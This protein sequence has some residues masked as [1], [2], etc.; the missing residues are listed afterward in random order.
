MPAPVTI[1][2]FGANGQLGFELHRALAPLGPVHALTRKQADLADAHQALRVL[3]VLKPGVVVN[4]AAYT[5]VDKAEREAALCHAINAHTQQRLSQWA[6]GNNARIV[7]YSTDYVF[8]GVKPAAD[9]YREDDAPNPQSVYGQ[10]KL[11]G[12]RLT[13]ASGAAHLI[14]RTSWVV[15]VH[16]GNFAKTMLR[17]ARERDALKVVADQWGAPTTAALIADVTAHVLRAR[18]DGR[19]ADGVYHLAA[20]GVT[21]WCEYARFVIANALEAG[22]KLRITPDDVEAITASQYPTPAKRPANSRLCT[23]KLR[24]TFDLHLPDWRIGVAQ[25]VQQLSE[26]VQ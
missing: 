13:Q 23:D 1:A 5:A 3:D 7:Y 11:A 17:L 19:G 4:A 12:E 9:R 21:N 14:F 8:D 25:V 2:L 24:Q 26:Q 15:G 18:L 10:S 16:G 20:D 22:M 6:E